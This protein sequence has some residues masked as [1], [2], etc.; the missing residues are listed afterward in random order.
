MKNIN[1]ENDIIPIGEFK[2][3]LSKW[4]KNIQH[5]DHPV[6]ITQNGRPAGVLLSPREFDLLNYNQSLKSSVERG[7]QNI[8]DG[9]IYST[10]ELKSELANKRSLRTSK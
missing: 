10:E 6:I 9:Q 7:L 3:N 1:I 2:A 8:E 5:S 4:M